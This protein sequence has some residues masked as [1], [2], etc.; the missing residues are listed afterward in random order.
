M[1]SWPDIEFVE[2]SV[3][4]G[5]IDSIGHKDEQDAAVGVCPGKG[6][7]IAGVSK[8][9][10]TC[11]FGYAGKQGV[12]LDQGFVE[13]QSSE[14]AFGAVVTG[15]ESLNGLRGNDLFLAKFTF[16]EIK[17]H[18]LCEVCRGG[19]KSGVAGYAPHHRC[20]FVVYPT[21]DLL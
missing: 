14:V 13:A 10:W 9:L 19:K 7:G 16:I 2:F 12:V 21:V 15:D 4:A 5:R 17:L 6:A 1:Y 20:T 18:E 11:V 3:G 8:A